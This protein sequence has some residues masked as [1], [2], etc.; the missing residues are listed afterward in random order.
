MLERYAT[1][2][3]FA[4]RASSA[5]QRAQAHARTLI[6]RF[7][8]RG[9]K[10]A[11]LETPTRAL[12]GGNMQKL[13]LGRAL[14]GRPAVDAAAQPDRR[15]PADLGPGHRRRRLR[16]PAVARRL[17][18]RRAVLLISED[19]DEIFALADRIA[20]MHHGRLDRRAA[21]RA[22]GRWRRSASR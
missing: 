20:V 3:A 17:R 9:T 19:L 5:A 7:D 12:S 2:R 14:M 1:P 4:R 18:G 21:G 22:T 6:E 11:G 10:A 8:V 13:I 16:A 15:Q